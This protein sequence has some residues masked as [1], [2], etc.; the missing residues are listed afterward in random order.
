MSGIIIY[1]QQKGILIVKHFMIKYLLKHLI[2]QP[3]RIVPAFT[4]QAMQNNTMVE[5]PKRYYLHLF[6]FF[7]F[8]FKNNFLLFSD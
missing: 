5:P 8:L 2:S 1:T 7:F 6:Y 3:K 4:Y